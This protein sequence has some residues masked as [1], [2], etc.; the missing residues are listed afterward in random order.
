MNREILFR[1]KRIDN[2]EWCIGCVM[3]HDNDKATIFRQHPGHGGL[4]GIEVD[5]STVCQ[6]TGLTDKN[7]RKIWENDV[8]KFHGND[9]D[10]VKIVFGEFVVIETETFRGID[11][12]VGWHYEVLPTDELSKIEPFNCLMPINKYYVEI[13]DAEVVGNIFDNSEL[14]EVE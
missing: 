4:D 6:Y 13:L 1:G 10:L 9:K 11:K 12:V 3:F 2:G 8:V 5:P 14:L 7:G